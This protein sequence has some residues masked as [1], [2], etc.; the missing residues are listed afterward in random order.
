M[1]K[2]HSVVCNDNCND[3]QSPHRDTRARAHTHAHTS[4][5]HMLFSATVTF[6]ILMFTHKALLNIMCLILILVRTVLLSCSYLHILGVTVSL[7]LH[8]S[9]G[10]D[11]VSSVPFLMDAFTSVLPRVVSV[12]ILSVCLKLVSIFICEFIF[13]NSNMRCYSNKCNVY[14]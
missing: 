12:N 2:R 8:Y 7:Y 13:L 6:H 5:D 4:H 10:F 9:S 1:H 14:S 11:I 3:F